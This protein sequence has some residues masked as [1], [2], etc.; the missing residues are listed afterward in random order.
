MCRCNQSLNK[1]FNN[2][3]N[4]IFRISPDFLTISSIRK[5]VNWKMEDELQELLRPSGP[6][7][8]ETPKFPYHL[9][10]LD[11]TD[12]L[13]LVLKFKNDDWLWNYKCEAPNTKSFKVFLHR[14]DEVKLAF[15]RP[16]EIEVGRKSLVSIKPH[17][18]TSSKYVKKYS[19]ELRQCYY[20][21][22]RSLMFYRLYTKNNCEH[23]C[24]ANFT[25]IE[26]G[27]VKFSM[28]SE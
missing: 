10:N 21:S 14:P 1:I 6:R 23:E 2:A 8:S 22:E 17:V 28:P 25:K 7:P 12:T 27:C 13:S 20:S 26:C 16:F 5:G 24:L 18:I 19:P 3:R 4:L 11:E 9:V 15:D